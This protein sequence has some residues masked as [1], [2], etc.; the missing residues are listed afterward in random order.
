MGEAVRFT[1]ACMF[2]VAGLIQLAM[3]QWFVG[4]LLL[5]CAWTQ[6]ELQRLHDLAEFGPAGRPR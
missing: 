6:I 3:R 5:Y 1:N 4:A 2:T